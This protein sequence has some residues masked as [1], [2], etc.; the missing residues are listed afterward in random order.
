[1]AERKEGKGGCEFGFF[2]YD[3]AQS[4]YR[5]TDDNR[6]SN[7]KVKKAVSVSPKVKVGGN[8]KQNNLSLR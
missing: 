8:C 2:Y 7:C 4:R 6:L 5:W 1:M 3:W